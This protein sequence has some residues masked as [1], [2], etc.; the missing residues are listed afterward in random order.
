MSWTWGHTNE[1]MC[2]LHMLQRELYELQLFGPSDLP[3][4]EVY[5]HYR[6][7]CLRREELEKEISA[8]MY[9]QVASNVLETDR[10]DR[11]FAFPP[12]SQ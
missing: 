9:Q 2:R 1:P 7:T 12:K 5:E 6:K 4:R 8:L 3:G 11:L 10:M